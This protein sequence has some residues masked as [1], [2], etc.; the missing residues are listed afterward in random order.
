MIEGGGLG[1]Y[2][3]EDV[4]PI[5][6]QAANGVID[7][8]VA[9]ER[10]GRRVAAKRTCATSR[11]RSRAGTAPT[12][13]GCATRSPRTGC[14]PTTSAPC[15]DDAGRHRLGAG[16]AARRSAPAS[17]P[18][19]SRIEGRPLGV[20]ANNPHHLGGAID[21]P[22]A[23]KAARFIQLC[24]AFDLPI[25]FLCDTPGFMVGPE[26]EKTALVRHVSRMFITGASLSVPYLHD[27]P[28][29]ELR[30]GRAGD[31]RRPASRRRCSRS[32]GRPA[33]SARWAWRAR[34]GSA[35]ARSWRRSPIRPSA[36]APTRQMVAR[37]YERGQGDQ[38][39]RL[40]RDRRRDRPRRHPALDRA[41]CST[42]RRRREGK[43]RPNIDAW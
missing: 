28:A 32:P 15:S 20:I 7:V 42:C 1:V 41:R 17:S 29:Q 40:R 14:A 33:S 18:R 39:R 16:A 36:S 4:G 12:S 31:G 5:G 27:R 38:H 19:W 34:S 43:R 25:L 30:A 3:P 11:A 2:A 13:A 9:D 24:D 23:D 21:A 22:A 6:V 37:A 35:S 10:R 26:A 8:L